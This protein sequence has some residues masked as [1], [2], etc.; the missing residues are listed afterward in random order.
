MN[1]DRPERRLTAL[2]ELWQRKA[3]MAG[4]PR[5]QDFEVSELKPWLGHITLLDVEP[6]VPIVPAE[7]SAGAWAGRE[8]RFPAAGSG[9]Y[10]FRVRLAGTRRVETLGRDDTG[11]YLAGDHLSGDHPSGGPP[12]GSHPSGGGTAGADDPRQV[13]LPVALLNRCVASGRPETEAQDATDARG[14]VR[15][16][17]RLVMPLAS[18]GRQI[19][20]LMV[21]EFAERLRTD[22]R[23]LKLGRRVARYA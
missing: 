13:G 8:S 14:L 2:L 4:I 22:I 3:A 12:A 1:K 6:M 23:G 20:K 16:F 9:A 5:R 18:D 19:D 21:A 11:D 17:H 10:R 7:R 15:R